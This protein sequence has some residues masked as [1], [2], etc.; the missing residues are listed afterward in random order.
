MKGRSIIL[1]TAI[2][3]AIAD[4]TAS[5]TNISDQNSASFLILAGVL[6]N[7]NT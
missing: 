1:L 2:S 5:T 6:V 7:E 3:I 4:D